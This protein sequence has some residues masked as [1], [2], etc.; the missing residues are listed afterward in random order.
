MAILKDKVCKDKDCNQVFK[1]FSSFQKY[2]GYECDAKNRQAKKKKTISPISKKRI[3][4][5][6]EYR[7]VRDRYLKENPICQVKDC[8]NPSTHIHHVNGRTG[9]RLYDVRY[10]MA[11]G[12]CCHPERIHENPTWARENGY[13][14]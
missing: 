8:S 2:C 5:L 3:E 9:K 14:I 13:L 6:A 10:F 1:P 7:T 12:G 4:E 11:V